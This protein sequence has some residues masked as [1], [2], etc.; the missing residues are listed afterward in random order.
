MSE[1]KRETA[2]GYRSETKL[3]KGAME[4][5]ESILMKETGRWN[6]ACGMTAI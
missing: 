1:A 6:E 2:T 3:W 4:R 5:S